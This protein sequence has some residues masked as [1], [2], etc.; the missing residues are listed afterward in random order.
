[1]DREPPRA[2]TCAGRTYTAAKRVTV[3]L[4][5]ENE[6]ELPTLDNWRRRCAGRPGRCFLAVSPAYQPAP[7]SRVLP[8]LLICWITYRRRNHHRVLLPGGAPDVA[9]DERRTVTDMRNWHSGV[10]GGHRIVVVRRY[11]RNSGMS[12][13]LVQLR[14]DM[15]LLFPLAGPCCLP[16]DED[17]LGYALHALLAATFGDIAPKPFALVAPRRGD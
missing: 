6:D 17:D 8:R 11:T 3:A 4:R 16:H 13:T 12:L 9:R 7:Y 10:H 15:P 5:L 2:G 14:P 1:M